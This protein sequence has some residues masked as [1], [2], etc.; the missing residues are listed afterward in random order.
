M[1]NANETD[2]H[3]WKLQNLTLWIERRCLNGKTPFACG[4][5]PDN[6][7]DY[8]SYHETSARFETAEKALA[9]IETRAKEHLHITA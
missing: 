9:Y 7:T 1:E 8:G 2:Y 6:R 3:S 5:H 4:Y